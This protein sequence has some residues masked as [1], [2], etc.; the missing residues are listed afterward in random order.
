MI[1]WKYVP[2]VALTPGQPKEGGKIRKKLK[3]VKKVIDTQF[4]FHYD[5]TLIKKC[6][7]VIHPDDIISITD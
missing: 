1:S 7:N 2:K 6:P 3:K 4:R 5:T